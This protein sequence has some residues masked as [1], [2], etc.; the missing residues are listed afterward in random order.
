M[1]CRSFHLPGNFNIIVV[2]LDLSI[3]FFNSFLVWIF[4]FIVK[5]VG[6]GQWAVGS[7][8]SAVNVWPI[9]IPGVGAQ[10]HEHLS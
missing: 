4:L 10:R 2:F 9:F 5:I 6:S 7:R 1:Y 8:Q 3:L